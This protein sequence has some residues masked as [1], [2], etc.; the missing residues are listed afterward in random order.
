MSINTIDDRE[1]GDGEILTNFFHPET[2]TL[3]TRR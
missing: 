1:N 3:N 2:T